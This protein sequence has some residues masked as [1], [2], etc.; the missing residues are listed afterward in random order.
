MVIGIISLQSLQILYN[1]AFHVVLMQAGS[2]SCYYQFRRTSLKEIA[3]LIYSFYNHQLNISVYF[4]LWYF[5]ILSVGLKNAC[6]HFFNRTVGIL[7]L[8]LSAAQQNAEYSQW[9][10]CNCK[11]MRFIP[12]QYSNCNTEHHGRMAPSS[13]L[14]VLNMNVFIFSTNLCKCLCHT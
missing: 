2:L 11:R 8:L 1:W 12:G 13:S 3:A 4:T 7:E 14:N 9:K 6:H 10:G 5:I